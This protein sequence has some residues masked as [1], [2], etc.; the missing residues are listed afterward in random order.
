[1]FIFDQHFLFSMSD[2]EPSNSDERLPLDTNAPMIDTVDVFNNEIN[3]T[4]IL[5][6]NR[7]VIIDFHRG[8]W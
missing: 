7:G 4:K 3:L 5:K 6:E 8:A 1:M 2:K